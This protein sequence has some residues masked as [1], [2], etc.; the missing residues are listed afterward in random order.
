MEPDETAA[1]DAVSD[2]RM[3]F[4]PMD[5][6]PTVDEKTDVQSSD[7]YVPSMP[8]TDRKLPENLS[9]LEDGEIED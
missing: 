5:A 7:D 3:L 6:E 9:D 4:A 2:V 8:V 1:M